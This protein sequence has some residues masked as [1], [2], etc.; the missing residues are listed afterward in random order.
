MI[1]NLAV[2][3]RQSLDYK[4]SP[5]IGLAHELALLDH[6]LAIQRIRFG[7]RI[8]IKVKAEPDALS[9]RVPSMLLQP[10]VENAFRHGVEGKRSGGII[11]VSASMK[12]G[13]LELSVMDNGKGLPKNWKLQNSSGH[14]LRVTRERLLAMYGGRE[15]LLSVARRV[16]GGTELTVRLPLAQR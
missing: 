2:L 3:L 7:D 11:V 1:S 12:D 13:F 15:E 5:A 10:L 14:G 6:Y 9:I 8:D 4:D 16:G